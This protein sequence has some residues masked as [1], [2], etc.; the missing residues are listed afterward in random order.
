M[1]ALAM[2]RLIAH[3]LNR[4]MTKEKLSKAALARRMGLTEE[5]DPVKVER[6]LNE[7]LPPA[8]W[9]MFS[10]RMIF[11]GRRVCAARKPDCAGCGVARWCPRRGVGP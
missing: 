4:V 11:H 9:T 8:E 1:E 10:H 5:E 2:K 3:E 7:L 6:D